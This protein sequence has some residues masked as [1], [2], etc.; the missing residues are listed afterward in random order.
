MVAIAWPPVLET[1]FT[2]SSGSGPVVPIPFTRALVARVISLH[3]IEA[4]KRS[5]VLINY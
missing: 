2:A 4:A 5:G 1:L 3:Q